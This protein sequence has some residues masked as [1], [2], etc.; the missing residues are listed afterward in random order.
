MTLTVTT[1]RLVKRCEQCTIYAWKWKAEH[2]VKGQSCSLYQYQ[3]ISC[4]CMVKGSDGTYGVRTSTLTSTIVLSELRMVRYSRVRR[5]GYKLPTLKCGILK[6]KLNDKSS[7][8]KQSGV[9][10]IRKFTLNQI[11]DIHGNE[12][13]I[14]VIAL[15]H[16]WS[17]CFRLF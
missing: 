11:P 5:R 2:I 6:C 13:Y 14:L 1:A 16:D 12:F 8:S 3:S 7:S 17:M 10:Q 15:Y 9:R 4:P